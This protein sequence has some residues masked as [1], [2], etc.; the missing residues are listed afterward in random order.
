MSREEHAA[1]IQRVGPLMDPW[2]GALPSLYA[3]TS[4]EASW[5]KIIWSG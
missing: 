5:D 2:Q 4:T 3:A 1:G